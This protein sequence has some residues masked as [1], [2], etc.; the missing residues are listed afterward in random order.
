MRDL[1]Q[2]RVPA[3]PNVMPL[4]YP[5][6]QGSCRLEFEFLKD[7]QQGSNQE[8]II[9][10]CILSWCF[11]RVRLKL[12]VPNRSTFADSFP[13]WQKVI[14]FSNLLR[15]HS[16]NKQILLFLPQNDQSSKTFGGSMVSPPHFPLALAYLD[17]LQEHYP[18]F[19]SGRRS[20][21]AMPGIQVSTC[22][23]QPQLAD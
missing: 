9:R 13:C 4:H 8:Q 18:P 21:L 7:F 19:P 10:H 15:T 20:S 11:T 6:R 17:H 16:L 2:Q 5:S 14:V 3:R 23:L 22:L 12:T 1:S